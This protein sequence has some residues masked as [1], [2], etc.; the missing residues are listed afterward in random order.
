MFDHSEEPKGLIVD[1]TGRSHMLELGRWG[2]FMAIASFIM[3]GL[4][5]LKGLFA[6]ISMVAWSEGFGLGG[7]FAGPSVFVMYLLMA[8]INFYPTYALYKYTS[9]IKRATMLEDQ[10]MFNEAFRYL[11]NAFKYLG[12]LLII[13]ICLYALIF[14]VAGISASVFKSM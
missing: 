5:V 1:E 6:M 2:R 14:I 9:L 13:I 12:V 11:K 8:G 10:Y 7:S 4:M 3:M